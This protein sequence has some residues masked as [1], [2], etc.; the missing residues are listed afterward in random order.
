[1][2]YQDQNTRYFSLEKNENLKGFDFGDT[3]GWFKS[4][5]VKEFSH[6]EFGQYTI[7]LDIEEGD[8]V[9]DFGA[10]IG[11]FIWQIKEKNPSKVVCIEPSHQLIDTLE[12]NLKSTKIPYKILQFGVG[13]ESGTK[14]IPAFDKEGEVIH[15]KFPVLTFMDMIK[16]SKVDKID[17]LKTDCEGGEYDIFNSENIWWI[18]E[19]VR[20]ISGEFHLESPEDKDKFEIFRNTYLR[21]FPNH[22]IYSIDMFDITNFLW[23]KSIPGRR[24]NKSFIEYYNQ[25]IVNIDNR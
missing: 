17:F 7:D 8:I 11:P 25:I 15:E 2:K 18:K 19:N 21:L 24:D 13:K 4:E 1:M 16:E 3:Y 9:F 14:N 23:E 5:L 22:K 6:Y 10:S 12:K 20:K